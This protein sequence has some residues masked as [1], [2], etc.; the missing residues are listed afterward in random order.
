MVELQEQYGDQGFTVIAIDAEE[1]AEVV[2]DFVERNDV[3]YL[4][5]LGDIDVMRAYRVSAHPMIVL[6]TPQGTIHEQY[7]G[8]REKQV[9][10]QGVQALLGLSNPK[11]NP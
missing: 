8:W 1:E 3:N 6:V 4:N 10:E 5:L 7:L 9:L 11:G 2:R